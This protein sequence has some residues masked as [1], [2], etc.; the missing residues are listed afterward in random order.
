MLYL[1]SSFK[2]TNSKVYKQLLTNRKIYK[3]VEETFSK[4]NKGDVSN[5]H[6][7]TSPLFIRCFSCRFESTSQISIWVFNAALGTN[8]GMTKSS[9]AIL[10]IMTLA[11][12]LARAT[13]NVSLNSC[14]V[15][16]K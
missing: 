15:V 16:V 11:L 10:T 1:F 8:I 7:E 3:K 13:V 14:W 9:R 6:F 2:L 12:S 5:F 4:I